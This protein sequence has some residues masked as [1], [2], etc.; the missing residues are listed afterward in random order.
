MKHLHIVGAIHL[1]VLACGFGAEEQT[2]TTLWSF[3]GDLDGVQRVRSN[4]GESGRRL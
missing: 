1:V 4:H 3:A 2:L